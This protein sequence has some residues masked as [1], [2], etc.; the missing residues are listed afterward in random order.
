M[1]S[2]KKRALT[3]TIIFKGLSPNYGE[4]V[5]NVSEL[6]KLTHGGGTLLLPLPPSS[7]VRALEVFERSLPDRY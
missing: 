7:Q 1:A 6:K 5:G 2:V 3:L 4:S